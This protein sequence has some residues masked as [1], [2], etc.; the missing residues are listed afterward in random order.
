MNDGKEEGLVQNGDQK[1]VIQKVM[2]DRPFSAL[3]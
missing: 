2:N 3:N 1:R